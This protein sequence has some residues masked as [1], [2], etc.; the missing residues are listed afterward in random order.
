MYRALLLLQLALFAVGASAQAVEPDNRFARALELFNSDDHAGSAAILES[1][2]AEKP[3]QAIYW[4]NLGGARLK[5]GQLEPAELAY[6]KVIELKSPL[7]DAARFYQS[8][9]LIKQGKSAQAKVL[10]TDLRSKQLPPNLSAAVSTTL[11]ELASGQLTGAS[12]ADA[13]MQAY[14]DR[15]Y[16]KAVQSLDAAIA[17]RPTG[18]AYFLK[19]LSLLRLHDPQGAKR[20]FE[21]ASLAT[22]ASEDLRQDARD[23]IRQ[24]REGNWDLDKRYSV[25]A[26]FSVDENTNFFAS[27]QSEVTEA[28]L[29]VHVAATL[30]YQLIKSEAMGASLQYRPQWDEIVAY[31]DF[32]QIGNL[33]RLQLFASRG[34]WF[35][36]ISPELQHGILGTSPYLLAPGITIRAERS[37]DP[38]VIGI[39]IQGQKNSGIG[40][41]FSYLSG[42]VSTA[43]VYWSYFTKDAE[44]WAYFTGAS[45]A[46]GDLSLDGD[47]LPLANKS[48]GGGTGIT[49]YPASTFETLVSASYFRKSFDTLSQPGDIRRSDGLFSAA[50]TLSYRLSPRFKPYASASLNWNSSTLDES[51]VSDL[52][53]KQWI[54]GAG[55]SWEA[56]P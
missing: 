52:N 5:L 21:Q 17:Q 10:L 39:S 12:P 31:S 26:D 38:H 47:L 55:L 20:S 37:W 50:V 23:F 6:R 48:F 15:D 30:R 13:A 25:S 14:K 1:L 33:L 16:P 40:D 36:S 11:M 22:D 28:A 2:V 24:I 51:S 9:A 18:N 43:R 4:F 42:S 27:G 41:S 35:F 29:G 7:S 34:A 8:A 46:I 53:Y 54:F 32:R 3:D 49:F 45:E 44:Y 56:L 19:G